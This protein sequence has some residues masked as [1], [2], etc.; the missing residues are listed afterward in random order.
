MH[1][2]KFS[3]VMADRGRRK[4]LAGAEPSAVPVGLLPKSLMHRPTTSPGRA[5]SLPVARLTA[6]VFKIG[7]R[8]TVGN[9]AMRPVSDRRRHARV[10]FACF[11]L[12]TCHPRLPH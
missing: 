1:K 7:E 8:H 9:E 4:M 3:K 5:P 2:K 10:P 11:V 6:D 12:R